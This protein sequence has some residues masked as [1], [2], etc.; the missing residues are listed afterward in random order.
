MDKKRAL[1]KGLAAL[2]PEDA[3]KREVE[4]KDSAAIAYLKVSEIQPSRFQPREDFNEERL[5]ELIS[6][7]KE[8]GFLQPILVHKTADG[9]ELIAGERRLR[10]AKSLNMLEIPAIVKAVSDEDV[11][12][13]SII[14]NVQ[15][16]E[17]NPIEE[18][19]AFYQLMQEF[20]FT[21]ERLAQSVGK[22]RSTVANILR[23]LNLPKEIQ[24]AVSRGTITM[25]HA[26]SLLALPTSKD[27]VAFFKKSVAKSLSVRELENLVQGKI[28]PYLCLVFHHLYKREGT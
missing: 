17:L 13:L 23:L 15:R 22:D 12:V 10:A 1:G 2:I 6:S 3:I 5:Q 25:G 8:K 26:R 9:Y 24:D 11:L 20:Y 21:Q 4:R 27:Q 18:A 19:H 14:E 7:I 16:E 28:A